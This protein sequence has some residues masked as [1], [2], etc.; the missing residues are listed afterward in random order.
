MMLSERA[1]LRRTV[2]KYGLGGFAA[3]TT[4]LL[5][6]A[7]A[8]ASSGHGRIKIKHA[9][10]GEVFHGDYRVGNRYLPDAFERINYVLRDHRTGEAF[11]MDPRLIDIISHVQRRLKTNEPLQIL[12]GYRSPRTNANLSRKTSG[13]AKN[14]FHMYGQALDIRMPGYNTRR[15]RDVAKSLRAGGVGYYARSDFVHVDTGSVR[16]W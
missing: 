1:V 4:P 10:T 7:A 3:L 15:L 12:S 14:S 6:P 11:P 16:S 13:V 9:H 8:L 2:L 5:S